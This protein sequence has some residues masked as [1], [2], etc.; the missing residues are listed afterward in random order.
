MRRLSFV[1]RL[2]S[3]AIHSD[4]FVSGAGSEEGIVA[5]GASTTIWTP[6]T[7]LPG[8]EATTLHFPD[9]Y[10]GPV[11]ATLVRHKAGTPGAGA[12]L[13]VHG[14]IDYFFQEH[15]AEQCNAHGYDFYALDLRK[16][17]RSLGSSKHPNF[18][19]D[20]REYYPD[21]TMAINIIRQEEGESFPGA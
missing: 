7:L 10:D 6:D 13:Y 12:F 9:D 11:T 4:L 16:Y 21:I 1:L 5:T 14:Y 20:I 17:G 18:C 3:G 8:Y 2:S 19:K 15:F